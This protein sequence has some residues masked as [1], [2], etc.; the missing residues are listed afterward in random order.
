MVVVLELLLKLLTGRREVLCP[1]SVPILLLRADVKQPSLVACEHHAPWLAMTP[2]SSAWWLGPAGDAPLSTTT[3][4]ASSGVVWCAAPHQSG[5][6]PSRRWIPM[7]PTSIAQAGADP[8]PPSPELVCPIHPS[9]HGWAWVCGWICGTGGFHGWMDEMRREVGR[10]WG[11]DGGRAEGDG[12]TRSLMGV[13]I[14]GGG[15]D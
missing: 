12:E 7:R 2:L 6:P 14:D 13:G 15:G 1:P 11:G 8:A 4:V 3:A 9:I 10:R 5:R